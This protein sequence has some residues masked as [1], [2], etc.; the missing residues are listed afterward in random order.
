MGNWDIITTNNW[1]KMFRARPVITAARSFAT[2]A[3]ASHAPLKKVYGTS[4]RYAEAI[5]TSASKVLHNLNLTN[6][7]FFR[8]N[9]IKSIHLPPACCVGR[10]VG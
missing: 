6:F 3:T 1:K 7:K 10:Q 2:G 4:G 5:Y 9:G 8:I